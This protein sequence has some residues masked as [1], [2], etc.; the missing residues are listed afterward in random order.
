VLTP[1]ADTNELGSE[2]ILVDASGDEAQVTDA[3]VQLG[4]VF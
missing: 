1:T 4:H 2:R 3:P